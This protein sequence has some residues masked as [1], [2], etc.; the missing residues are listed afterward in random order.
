M[1][2]SDEDMLMLDVMW[3][4]AT[5]GA[6]VEASILLDPTL[7]GANESAITSSM[8]GVRIAVIPGEFLF[9]VVD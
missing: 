1:V 3:D 5:I 6:D 4:I 8:L 2:P 9:C 7:V